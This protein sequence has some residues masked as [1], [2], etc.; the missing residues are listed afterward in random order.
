MAYCVQDLIEISETLQIP[1]VLDFHHDDIHPSN[2]PIQDYFDR[3]FK[4]WFNRGIKPKVHVSNSVPGITS[5]DSKTARRKHSDYIQYL[6]E[7]LLTIQ[8]PIDVMLECKM[9]EQAIF[10]LL[11]N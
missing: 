9:K 10:K 8:F 5:S 4:V 1:L 11:T 6:H 2:N 3:V 7:S